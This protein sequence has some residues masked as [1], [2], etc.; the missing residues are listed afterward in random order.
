MEQPETSVQLTDKDIDE[1]VRFSSCVPSSTERILQIARAVEAEVARRLKEREDR[2]R[3]EQVRLEQ[4]KENIVLGEKQ[5]DERRQAQADPKLP[6][7][8]LTPL[9]ARHRDLDDQLRAR[10]AE[11]EDK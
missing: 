3:E 11:L 2:E 9:L 1:R 4:E 10:L 8:V 5:D 6:S 7:G